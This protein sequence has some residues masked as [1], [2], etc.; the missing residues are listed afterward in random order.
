L[1]EKEDQED[2]LRELILVIRRLASAGSG[3]GALFPD[4]NVSAIELVRDFDQRVSVLRED[5]EEQFS[6]S[7]VESLNLLD[8]KLSTMSRDGAEFDAD[9]WTDEAVRTS[10]HWAEVR[11]LAAAALDE[12]VPVSGSES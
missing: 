8:Q 12:L 6:S 11:T 1:F 2:P 5:Y 4:Q 3:Q 7:Q 10:E 9:I